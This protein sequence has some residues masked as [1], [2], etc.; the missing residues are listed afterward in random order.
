[1]GILMH[2]SVFKTDKTAH[3]FVTMT[4]QVRA[5]VE[6]DLPGEYIN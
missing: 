4:L 2:I 3:S 6:L 5:P 1:M